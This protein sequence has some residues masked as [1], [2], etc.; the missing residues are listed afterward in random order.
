V[1]IL[2]LE[3]NPFIAL[4]LQSIVE[5]EGHAASVCGAVADARRRLAEGLDFAFLDVDVTDGTSYDFARA[6]TERGIPFAF[7][8]GS[9]Q[10]DLPPVLRNATFIAKPF[11]EETIVR[12]LLPASPV[13]HAVVPRIRL[14]EERLSAA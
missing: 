11:L 10:S 8:S 13:R 14:A 6:L 7:V 3:D 4:D 1:R 12:A 9:R 2:I 5:S